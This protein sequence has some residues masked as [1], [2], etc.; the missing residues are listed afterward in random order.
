MAVVLFPDVTLR[1]EIVLSRRTCW[2]MIL[3]TESL[4]ARFML[5]MTRLFKSVP[6]LS[7]SMA[8]GNNS[9]FRTGVWTFF[10]LWLMF[11]LLWT[12]TLL[13]SPGVLRVR[14]T[15]W[16]RLESSLLRAKQKHISRYEHFFKASFWHL[17]GFSG[18]AE[19]EYWIGSGGSKESDHFCTVW[20]C[21][22]VRHGCQ[23]REV[24]GW[25][26]HCF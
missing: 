15:L 3:H 5:S 22:Y 7:K 14:I 1:M 8:A 4:R 11:F 12:E 9:P 23:R 10:C 21:T 18:G 17:R 2:S 25:P 6:R 20:R 19:S 16:N 26:Q 24:H 13:I